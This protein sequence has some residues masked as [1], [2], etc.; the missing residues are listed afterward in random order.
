MKAL[1]Y[2]T[3]CFRNTELSNVNPFRKR[4]LCSRSR[5]SVSCSFSMCK[6]SYHFGVDVWSVV[7]CRKESVCDSL[8]VRTIRGRCWTRKRKAYY[9]SLYDRSG[10]NSHWM[11]NWYRIVTYTHNYVLFLIDLWGY[12]HCG[13]SWPV[14]PASGDTE[15]DCGEADRM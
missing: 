13:H 5:F 7:Y 2:A 15:D 9:E 11:I 1:K 10:K 4:N 6:Y 12:W 3:S 8:L 14:V